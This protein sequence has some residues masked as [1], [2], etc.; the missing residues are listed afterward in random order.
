MPLI[1]S[2]L[3]NNILLYRFEGHGFPSVS[4]DL[5]VIALEAIDSRTVRVIFVVPQVFVGLHGRVELR[6][7][8]GRYGHLFRQ[9]I[10]SI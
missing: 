8:S 3:I 9:K 4:P 10:F 2:E 7:T 6:Y 1:F 5:Q